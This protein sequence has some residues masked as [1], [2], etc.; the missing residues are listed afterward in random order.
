MKRRPRKP[1]RGKRW[2]GTVKT[3]STYPPKGLFTK[4]ARTIARSLASKRV[5]PKGVGSGLRMLT[6]FINRAGRGLSRTRR[7]E[8][9]KAKRFLQERLAQERKR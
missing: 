9:Q 2:V 6:F 4:D 1:R 7:A 3:V 8:L 5:S